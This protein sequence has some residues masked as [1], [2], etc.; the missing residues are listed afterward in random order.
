MHHSR[1]SCFSGSSP[2]VSAH[3]QRG[4][5]WPQQMTHAPRAHTLSH[6]LLLHA[7][8][9]LPAALSSMSPAVQH[10]LLLC[11]QLCIT[12]PEK[13]SLTPGCVSGPPLEPHST[14]ITSSP[15]PT[16]TCPVGHEPRALPSAPTHMSLAHRSPGQWRGSGIRPLQSGSQLVLAAI[17]IT[18][19]TILQPY[20]FF[21]VS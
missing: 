14:L 6:L 21:Y 12:S 7:Q 20:D 4:L 1:L 3:S 15:W 9:P 11:S 2:I 19:P 13:P 18:S 16:P 5:L 10:P 17:F 8:F